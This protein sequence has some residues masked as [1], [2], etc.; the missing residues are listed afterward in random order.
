MFFFSPS[1]EV[2]IVTVY[3]S[4]HVFEKLCLNCGNL[5]VLFC[6]ERLG[7]DSK[8]YKA[9]HREQKKADISQVN[10]STNFLLTSL[11]EST[12]GLILL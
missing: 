12:L 5:C 7:N 8:H 6:L 9:L 1:G 11:V 2:A 3:Q 4:L 10:A